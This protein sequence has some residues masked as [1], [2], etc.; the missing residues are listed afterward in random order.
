[1]K[2]Y[3][4]QKILGLCQKVSS[5][6]PRGN[7]SGA[8][9][10]AS[11]LFAATISVLAVVAF[12][13]ATGDIKRTGNYVVTREAFYIAEAGLQ[14]SLNYL[15][16]DSNGDYPGEAGQGFTTVLDTFLT[17]HSAELVNF[18]FG[19]GTYTVS[20]A[21][22]DDNDDDLT[23]DVDNTILLNSIG[24]KDA[25]S[26]TIQAVILHGIFG[27]KHAITTEANLT[28]NGN[29]TVQGT[30][31]SIHSNADIVG[32]SNNVEQGTTAAGVCDSPCVAAAKEVLP[33]AEPEDFKSY[34]NFILT[35]AGA[36]TD[37][38]GSTVDISEN[39]LDNWS[40]TDTGSFEGWTLNGCS[41]DGMFYAETSIK[42]TGNVDKCAEGAE[43]SDK[44]KDTD[45]GDSDSGDKDKDTD[46]GDSDSGDKDKN[47]D[48]GD[49]DSSD[50][51]KD[52]DSGD[53]DSGDKDKDTDAGDSDSGDKDKDTDAES[54]GDALE[55]TLIAEG[56]IIISGNPNIENY[57]NALH[58]EEIQNLLFVSGLD[59]DFGGNLSQ[60]VEGIAIAKEQ[61]SLTGS[62]SLSGYV[63][64]SD[65]TS[66]GSTVSGNTVSGNFTITYNSLKNPF[67][68][69]QVT[70]LS[71]KER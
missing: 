29:P 42:L 23:I 60:S 25:A 53:S 6:L 13:W 28:I 15:N 2:K 7:E 66:D 21:D 58:P 59:L 68:N 8:A 16:Y 56:D 38:E 44:D 51:D 70:L 67:L 52:T 32:N 43:D 61:I 64:A 12:Q 49:S 3:L 54:S 69:D 57:K 50:K 24:T 31:G 65:V 41:A 26:V 14:K 35:S 11:I 17:D 5:R 39:K 48:S 19:G 9:L 4:G 22:N 36:I 18:S 27:A 10:I 20:L 62:A 33:I 30:F 47:T 46:S 40:Y 37:V 45:S 34:A 1:M 55:L 63:I 71:W